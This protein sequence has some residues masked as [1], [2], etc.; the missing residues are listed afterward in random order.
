M[1]IADRVDEIVAL[2]REAELDESKWP[3]ASA[4]IDDTCG[5]RGNDLLLVGLHPL[6]GIGGVVHAADLDGDGDPDVLS[7]SQ[8]DDTIAWYE[9]LSDHGDDYGDVPDAATLAA[10]LP[11]LLLGRV[12]SSGDRDVFR[13]AT[14]NGTLIVNANGPT[15]TV[16]RLLDADGEQLAANDDSDGL[17]F[18][19]EAEVGGWHPLRR[20]RCLCGKYGTLHAVNRVRGRLTRARTNKPVGRP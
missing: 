14:G 16:G 8:G 7:A 17:N 3:A 11:A 18:V 19:I 1:S 20:G 4:L 13:V 10:T 2:L 15:D 9:N 5:L 6:G 12:E